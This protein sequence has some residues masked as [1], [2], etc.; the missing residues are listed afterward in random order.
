MS[1]LADKEALVTVI[2]HWLVYN[3]PNRIRTVR[4]KFRMTMVN[5]LAINVLV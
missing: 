4:T 5:S 3:C 2:F 1:D